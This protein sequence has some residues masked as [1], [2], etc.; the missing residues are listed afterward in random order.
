MRVAILGNGDGTFQTPLAYG[1]GRGPRSV[2]IVDLDGDL[3]PDLAT[4]NDDPSA[5]ATLTIWFGNGDGTFKD[6]SDY[7]G[8]VEPWSIEAGDFNGDGRADLALPD[9]SRQGV[10]ILLNTC[11][12]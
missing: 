2:V 1:T 7:Q 10:N 4:A 5:V 11:L 8:G 9:L 12:D 3:K 6:R